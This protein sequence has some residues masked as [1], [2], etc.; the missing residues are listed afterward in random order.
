MPLLGDDGTLPV[1]AVPR[2]L[3]S[4]L[5]MPDPNYV[6]HNTPYL[7]Q[8][9]A[10]PTETLGIAGTNG[11]TVSQEG[12]YDISLTVAFQS[13]ANVAGFRGVSLLVGGVDRC[14]PVISGAAGRADLVAAFR[15]PLPA[16]TFIQATVLQNSGEVL[17]LG[18]NAR[19]QFS[20]V[21][22]G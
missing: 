7:L 17:L 12:F 22:L 1:S 4:Q 10:I 8:W 15:A 2:P 3:I 20:V 5:L 6:P 9:G 14:S 18:G 21:R 19:T 11:F 13:T 16:G